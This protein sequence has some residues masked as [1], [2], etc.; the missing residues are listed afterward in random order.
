MSFWLHL[1]LR[2]VAALRKRGRRVSSWRWPG[3][4]VSGS[5]VPFGLFIAKAGSVST[6]FYGPRSTAGPSLLL[7]TPSSRNLAVEPVGRTIPPCICMDRVNATREGQFV[8]MPYWDGWIFTGDPLRKWIGAAIYYAGERGV[9]NHTGEPVV[10]HDCPFCG[11]ELPFLTL[12][13]EQADGG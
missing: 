5:T 1:L 2:A 7:P 13:G 6:R 4:G 3:S 12:D 10:W 8:W 9:T 11:G